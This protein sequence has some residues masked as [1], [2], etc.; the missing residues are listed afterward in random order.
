[1]KN[2]VRK[3]LTNAIGEKMYKMYHVN[4]GWFSW[5]PML[6]AYLSDYDQL[7]DEDICY[8]VDDSL[9]KFN[10][11]PEPVMKKLVG[12]VSKSKLVS[13]ITFNSN[14]NLMR[15]FQ[16]FGVVYKVYDNTYSIRVDTRYDFDEVVNYIENFKG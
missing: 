14:E 13:T 9:L 1:M 4:K 6:N 5:N 7:T 3:M 12:I 15:S 8:I 10:K 2:Y 16:K 11:C